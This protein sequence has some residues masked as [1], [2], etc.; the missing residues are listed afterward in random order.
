MATRVPGVRFVRQNQ[1][2]GALLIFGILVLLTAARRGTAPTARQTAGYLVAA[3]LIALA[4]SYVPD[5]A[6]A[7]LVALLFVLAL[8][9]SDTIG[10]LAQQFAALL[11]NARPG[12]TL[13]ERS[14]QGV[15]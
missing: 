7:F 12:P 3:V 14:L 5:L 4:T 8:D 15:V 11:N 9:A 10:R 2:P 13:R 6:V 1:V